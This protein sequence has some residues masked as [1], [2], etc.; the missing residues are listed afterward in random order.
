MA[1][2]ISI[3]TPLTNF[4][5]PAPG[6]DESGVLEYWSDGLLNPKLEKMLQSYVH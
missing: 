1:R 4:D 2:K 5:K 6:S 3:I